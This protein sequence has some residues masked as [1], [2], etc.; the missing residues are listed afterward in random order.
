[1]A[2]SPVVVLPIGGVKF[3][4]NLKPLKSVMKKSRLVYSRILV[5]DIRIGIYSFVHCFSTLLIG[6]YK[7]VIYTYSKSS[8]G[9]GIIHT[10]LVFCTS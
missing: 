9:A 10:S 1:M 5:R 6:I 2:G 3:Y 8:N 4:E 7:A